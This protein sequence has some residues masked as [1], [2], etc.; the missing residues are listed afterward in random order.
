MDLVALAAASPVMAALAAVSVFALAVVLDRLFAWARVRKGLSHPE[1][2]IT[3]AR[4]R[5]R[6][7]RIRERAADLAQR[8]PFARIFVQWLDADG[9]RGHVEQAVAFEEACLDRNVWILD[10]AATIGPLLGI[11]GTL[12]GISTSFGGFRT[13]AAL[14]PATVSQGISLA[15]RS[16]AVGLVMTIASVVCA[17]LFRRMTDRAVANME[18]FGEALLAVKER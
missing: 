16:T 1:T 17:H 18:H 4:T 8:N 13:I 9:H 12:V 15:L 10:C 14:N 5:D 11:L 7:P 3:L 2:L 6:D